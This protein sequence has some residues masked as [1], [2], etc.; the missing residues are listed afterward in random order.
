M[1]VMVITSIMLSIA[2]VAFVQIGHSA[3]MK[4]SV[5]SVQSAL[6]LARQNAITYRVRTTFSY[7]NLVSDSELPVGCFVVTTNGCVVGQTNRLDIGIIFTNPSKGG[8]TFTLDGSFGGINDTNIT[9][10]ERDKG[11]NAMSNAITVDP[12]TGRSKIKY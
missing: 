1:A 5:L 10:I 8:V 6:N 2:V 12:L 9:L 3:G 7:S 4:A 11:V